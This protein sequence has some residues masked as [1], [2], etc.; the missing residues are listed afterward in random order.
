MYSDEHHLVEVAAEAAFAVNAKAH[1]T[2]GKF[3][4]TRAMRLGQGRRSAPIDRR[5]AS[6]PAPFIEVT[7]AAGHDIAPIA[8]LAKAK[9]KRM[10]LPTIIS[11]SPSRFEQLVNEAAQRRHGCA[12]K[13]SLENISRGQNPAEEDKHS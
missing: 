1:A 11:L 3:E 13:E 9:T 12:P 4:L 6:R 2:L 10:A 8:K 5:W 7:M